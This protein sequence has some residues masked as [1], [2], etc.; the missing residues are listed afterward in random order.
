MSNP[1]FEI[2]VIA[3]RMM[4]ISEAARYVGLPTKRFTGACPVAPVAMP[5][6]VKRWDKIDLDQWLDLMKSG[7][8]DPDD[9][10]LSL[11]DQRAEK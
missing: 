4:S 9:D 7:H 6:D 10:V 11:L 8:A 5:G 3:P 2:K 1:T